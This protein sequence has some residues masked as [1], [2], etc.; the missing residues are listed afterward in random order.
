MMVM[1]KF[2]LSIIFADRQARIY[3]QS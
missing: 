1:I 3:L 2:Y